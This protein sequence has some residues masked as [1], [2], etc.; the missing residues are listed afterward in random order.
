M[1]SPDDAIR[2]RRHLSN[3]IIAAHDAER[4]RALFI[5]DA[6]VIVGDGALIIGSDSIVQAF[7]SQFS[8]IGFIAYERHTETIQVD[9]A[10]DRAA[11][12]GRWLG[13]WTDAVSLAG[14]YLAVWRRVVGQW[15]IESELYVTL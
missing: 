12:H 4:L 6:K 9:S 5:P 1:T 13:R 11:E 3:K 7:A 15:R 8:E 14:T 10:G 2:A